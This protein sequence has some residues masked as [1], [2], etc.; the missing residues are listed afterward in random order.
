MRQSYILSNPVQLYWAGWKTDTYSLGQEGWQ[1]SA[2]EDPRS[3][4]MRIAIRHPKAGIS[5]ISEIADFPY[6][7]DF[8]NALIGNTAPTML[9]FHDIHRRIYAEF[10]RYKGGFDFHAIDPRPSFV[11]REVHSIEDFAHFSKI[12]MEE[13]KHQ[14]LLKEASIQQILDMALQIQEPEQERIRAEMIRNRELQN[15][16]LGK[17]HTELRLVA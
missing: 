8:T 4:S 10:M 14:I 15:Y 7:S 13:P 5:G 3:R 17:L 9:R 16:R 2:E 1:I 11:E 12:G 6:R